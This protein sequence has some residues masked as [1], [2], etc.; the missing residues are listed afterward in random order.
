MQ[1]NRIIRKRI[2]K[3]ADGISLAADINA[4]ISSGNQGSN[5]FVRSESSNRI[6]QGRLPK[7]AIESDRRQQPNMEVDE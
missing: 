5:S 1:A 6:V 3:R 2:R 7:P 4:V